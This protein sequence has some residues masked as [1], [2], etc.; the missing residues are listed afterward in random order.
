MDSNNSQRNYD[1]PDGTMKRLT[2]RP[3]EMGSFISNIVQHANNYLDME[4]RLTSWY[5]QLS[6]R[7]QPWTEVSNQSNIFNRSEDGAKF[8]VPLHPDYVFVTHENDIIIPE[9]SEI[10]NHQK[11]VSEA[12]ESHH[13]SRPKM[14]LAVMGDNRIKNSYE[15]LYSSNQ[16]KKV[17]FSPRIES[18][19]AILPRREDRDRFENF[20]NNVRIPE[21]SEH[22][23]DS[24]NNK[25]VRDLEYQKSPST[26]NRMTVKE[27]PEESN[28]I[29]ER[30][31]QETENPISLPRINFKLINSPKQFFQQKESKKKDGDK[32]SALSENMS[33]SKDANQLQAPKIDVDSICEKV[34]QKLQHQQKIERERRGLI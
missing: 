9:N 18:S 5:Q 8:N 22:D 10:D 4:S 15:Q 31:I 11:S 29:I 17:S 1:V 3:S 28:T 30:L 26:R 14:N 33:K 7:V 2:W 27:S 34:I 25:K 23:E 32:D 19:A 6:Q 20:N 12:T 13:F 16:T 24:F 21:K